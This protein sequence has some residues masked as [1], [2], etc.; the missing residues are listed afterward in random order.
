M[1]L[2]LA[3]LLLCVVL[4]PAYLPVHSYAQR[5]TVNGTVVDEYGS[6][7]IGVN[8]SVEE[9]LFGASTDEN[10]QFSIAIPF[11]L[12]RERSITLR[13]EAAGYLHATQTATLVRGIQTFDFLLERDLLMLDEP[14][15][16]GFL[17]TTARKELGYSVAQLSSD[18]L[19]MA[20]ASSPLASLQ[21]RVAGLSIV[22]STQAPGDGYAVRLRGS[23]T[24][25]GDAGPLYVVDGIILEEDLVDL[26]VLDV[27]EVE[28]L[29]GAAG[30]ALYGSRG[31]GGVVQIAT[32][33]GYE[34]PLNQ[35]RVILRNEFGFQQLDNTPAINRSHNLVTN[36]DG[37]FL[38][39]AGE[40]VPFGSEAALDQDLN[41]IS[42]YDNAYSGESFDTFDQLF[43]S[44]ITY[45]NFIA[46]SGNGPRT[47]YHGSFTNLNEGGIINGLTG[48]S[49]QSARINVDH[50]VM[51]AWTMSASA[52]YATS[53]NDAPT[54]STA[55]SPLMA[56]FSPFRG[57]LDVTPISSFS[58]K[59]EDGSI[60]ILADPLARTEN[61]LYL[62]ETLAL[63]TNR[64]RL[65]GRFQ[66]NVSPVDWL[67]L[68]GGISYDRAERAH[69]AIYDP[70]FKTINPDTINEGLT[71]QR[72]G[73]SE[74]LHY[75]GA[76]SFVQ[77]F[78][79]VTL[80]SRLQYRHEF[81]KDENLL[82]VDDQAGATEGISEEVRRK[83]IGDTYFATVGLDLNRKFFV[84]GMLLREGN[85]LFGADER[86]QLYY[87]V[88]G[89]YR[90]SEESWWPSG[91]PE[92]KIRGAYGTA[93]R[94]PQFGA[95]FT[96]F[97]LENDALVR[98][99]LGNKALKPE[100]SKE[101]ELGLEVVL[102]SR[103]VLQA[104]HI[105]RD[106]K[107]QLFLVPLTSPLGFQA[108]WQNGGTIESTTLEASLQA[109]L[110]RTRNASLDIGL[111]FDRTTQ[112]VVS[113]PIDA[114]TGGPASAFYFGEGESMGTIYGDRFMRSLDDLPAGVNV[115][116]FDV[117]DEGFVVAVGE[118]NSYREGIEKQLWGTSVLT[119]EGS[120]AWGMP[121]KPE[122]DGDQSKI[123]D[124]QPDFSIGVPV[125]FR[126]KQFSFG[127]LW[128]A[129]VGGDLYNL[130]NQITYQS[131]RAADQDQAGK[132]D[133]LKKPSQY[134]EV[135]YDAGRLNDHFIEDASYIRLREA[136]LRYTIDGSN[137]SG[138]LG[139]TLHRVTFSLIGRNLLTF[140]DYS[141]F[142]P[143]TGASFSNDGVVGSDASLY[144]LD[145]FGYPNYR[146]FTGALEIQ[147]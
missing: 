135:L 91:I 65:L 68:E 38:D 116:A 47:N 27:T 74:A 43:D 39:L 14:V 132:L 147:F 118:G 49:R 90:L 3:S 15:V 110:I 77:N 92:F 122:N 145:S 53:S 134:Y 41:G 31:A 11:R 102:G 108:Q 35:M 100:R 66:L 5:A 32:R 29:K 127:M 78:D 23:N 60:S 9:L 93:G 75:D 113:L 6:P 87:Q 123:G 88:S 95:Q 136:A 63:S 48:Y 12:V 46:I 58:T 34:Q 17:G 76:A 143:A 44:G 126:F 131:G 69:R 8:V 51:P 7:L 26:D 98:L 146:T 33:R 104:A 45:S 137:L 20:P 111:V 129:S 72:D 28:I 130:T 96:T 67:E 54:L 119:D 89:A 103:V 56:R 128:Y 61:P 40:E 120:Y 71:E 4:G 57:L 81:Y 36:G 64:D 99:T 19:Q 139:R 140:T 138:F 10:G 107:D 124:A 24:I 115:N 22:R 114:F 141:G 125:N 121:F 117:N 21:G 80:R 25:T 13:V 42:F 94:R 84:D 83:V 86:W 37:A 79:Q 112:E 59:D 82:F 55:V 97:G 133:A 70:G 105:T 109:T 16:T 62:S 85:S 73:L 2:V 106:T 1:R 18:A 101:L 144:R 30:A 50:R 52:M 142:D